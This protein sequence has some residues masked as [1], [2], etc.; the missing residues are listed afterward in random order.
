MLNWANQ[1]NICCFLDNH[2]YNLSHHKYE[3]IVAVGT[4]RSI[5]AQAGNAFEQLQA[6]IDRDKDWVFGHLSYDLKNE[7][8]NL[9]SSGSDNVGFPDLFFFVPEIVVN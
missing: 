2:H 5:T 4:V 9:S 8:E 6:F 1:F 7:I 3:C